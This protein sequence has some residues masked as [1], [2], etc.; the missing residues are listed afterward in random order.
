M[1]HAKVKNV[2]AALTFISFEKTAFLEVCYSL[3]TISKFQQLVL[4]N[5]HTKTI[6]WKQQAPE[7]GSDRAPKKSASILAR[8]S[9]HAAFLIPSGYCSKD[10]FNDTLIRKNN[11]LST[12]SCGWIRFGCKVQI[13][14][15]IRHRLYCP[16]SLMVKFKSD[17]IY[18]SSTRNL[19]IMFWLCFTHA[20]AR[21]QREIHTR[22]HTRTYTQ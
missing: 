6:P 2:T 12:S 3:W 4:N 5:S 14:G 20:H 1:S 21:T 15:M 9:Y 18:F 19:F 8:Y 22:T 7:L 11:V 13:Q 17:G 16:Q 10:Y